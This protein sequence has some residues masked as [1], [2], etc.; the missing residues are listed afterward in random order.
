MRRIRF[1]CFYLAGT[2]ML[3]VCDQAP[4]M[5]RTSAETAGGFSTSLTSFSCASRSIPYWK[6]HNIS[7][8]T[9][10]YTFGVQTRDRSISENSCPGTTLPLAGRSDCVQYTGCEEVGALTFCAKPVAN[11][12]SPTYVGNIGTENISSGRE[13]RVS[14]I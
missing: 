9:V 3:G 2:V 5:I 7:D 14:N 11:H 12:D 6:Q 13:C 10:S 1:V 8:P 4:A